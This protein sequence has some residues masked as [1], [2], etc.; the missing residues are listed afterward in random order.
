[1]QELDGTQFISN[2]SA[3][4]CNKSSVLQVTRVINVLFIIRCVATDTK[5]SLYMKTEHC[6]STKRVKMKDI[7]LCVSTL[8]HNNCRGSFLFPLLIFKII[9]LLVISF[10]LKS[11]IQMHV[12]LY[13]FSFFFFY[14]I[15]LFL[16]NFLTTFDPFDPYFM[17]L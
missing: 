15:S 3:L 13:S 6:F 9:I 5:I 17:K 11:C 1:M 2:F 8:F 4:I 14:L 16:F 12:H 7:I 10:D